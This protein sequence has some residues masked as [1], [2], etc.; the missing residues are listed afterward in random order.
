MRVHY[1]KSILTHEEAIDATPDKS[2]TFQDPVSLFHSGWTIMNDSDHNFK[3]AITFGANGAPGLSYSNQNR[4]GEF[5]AQS[6]EA[7]RT[8]EYK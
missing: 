3:T 1:Y 7:L 2:V 4:K 8:G 5:V 6:I